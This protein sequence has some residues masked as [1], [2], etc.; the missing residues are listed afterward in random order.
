[1]WKTRPGDP[2][3]QPKKPTID[4]SVI[5]CLRTL[6]GANK[7]VST[8]SAYRTNLAQ[9]VAFLQKT[10]CTIASPADVTRVDVAE[11]LAHLAERDISGTTR[12]C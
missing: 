1:M 9:F 8:I 4:E 7:S 3:T 2:R 10:N 5:A 11:Y 12:A 6:T